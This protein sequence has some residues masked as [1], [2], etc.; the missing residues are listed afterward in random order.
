MDES[1]VVLLL[2]FLLW[3]LVSRLIARAD[4]F[5]FEVL[6]PWSLSLLLVPKDADKLLFRL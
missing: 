6:S 5:D 2:P 3:M 1:F 4:K